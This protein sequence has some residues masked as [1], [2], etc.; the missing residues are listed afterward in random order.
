MA[1]NDQRFL[2]T[3][4]NVDASIWTFDSDGTGNREGGTRTR[5]KYTFW[6]GKVIIFF[7]GSA[8]SN[9]YEYSFLEEDKTL[10]LIRKSTGTNTE[11]IWL[12]KKE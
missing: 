12:K 4:E 10:F 11:V 1:D 9:I 3:W 7:S 5:L 6:E 8:F 2:G